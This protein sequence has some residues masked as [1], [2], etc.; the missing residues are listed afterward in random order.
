M[1]VNLML[2]LCIWGEA[3]NLR[4]LPECLCFLYHKMMQARLID[5]RKQESRN[6]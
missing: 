1:A 6:K 3:G 5:E 4:H 2:W